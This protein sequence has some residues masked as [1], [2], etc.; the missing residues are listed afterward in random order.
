MKL[1]LPFSLLF[2]A[3]LL[4]CN[5]VK[6]TEKMMLGGDYDLAIN[7]ALEQLQKAK[8]KNYTSFT[9]LLGDAY[10]KA[11]ER[12]LDR[13]DYLKS[14]MNPELYAD[15]FETYRGLY[16][17][18]EKIKPVLPL[19]GKKFNLNDY[20]VPIQEY[21]LKTSDYLMEKAK[22]L[23]AIDKKLAYRDAYE[24]LLYIEKIN[25]NYKNVRGMLD[26][27]AHKGTDY[28]LVS[29]TNPSHLLL[30]RGF[31]EQL[32]DIPS[33]QINRKWT[34][35]DLQPRMDFGYDF[36]LEVNL[37]HI[38]ASPDEYYVEQTRF[39]KQI[40]DG[41]TSLKDDKGR[42]VKDS[43]GNPIQVDRY[44]TVRCN[45]TEHHQFKSLHIGAFTRLND[46]HARQEVNSFYTESEIFFENVYATIRGDRRALEN[47]HVNFLSKGP[48]PFPT[49]EQML[50]DATEQ[51][52]DKWVN[53]IR[54]LTGFN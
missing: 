20:S 15:I 14:Q 46:L 11:V 38:E 8:S 16:R 3:L 40:K 23:M 32:E 45:Y 22:G 34:V 43:L 31:K 41:Y 10:Q 5:P 12:D 33:K 37:S 13:I 36:S 54:N 53:Q 44:I 25:P 7:E 49:N 47:E 6:R 30:P 17:R 4:G 52:K 26:E 19:P 18:Q 50:Y 48:V 39:E 27:A 21:R 51:L 35:F 9:A 42:V 28:V 1:T 29:F 2:L 24:E